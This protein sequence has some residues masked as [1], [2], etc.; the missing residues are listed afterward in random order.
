MN[1]LL[2][3]QTL[4][5]CHQGLL[6]TWTLIKAVELSRYVTVLDQSHGHVN[7]GDE[8]TDSR[9]TSFEKQVT[10]SRFM[11]DCVLRGDLRALTYLLIPE[12]GVISLTDGGWQD[13]R[14]S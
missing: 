14:P 3:F 11:A 1:L 12:L 4:T 9:N 5:Q 8:V 6:S 2:D 10:L 13:N 7:D